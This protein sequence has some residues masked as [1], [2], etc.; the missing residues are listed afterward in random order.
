M[1]ILAPT[2]EDNHVGKPP[3]QE[4][5]GEQGEERKNDVEN[6]NTRAPPSRNLKTPVTFPSPSLLLYSLAEMIV[7]T[8]PL[9]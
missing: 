2:Q 1:H 3:V 4:D 5:E 8:K 6:R 9:E 7:N